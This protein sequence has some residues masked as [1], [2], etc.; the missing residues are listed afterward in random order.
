MGCHAFLQGV[1]L[2]RGS[3]LRLLCLVQRQERI[4]YQLSC[5]WDLSLLNSTRQL[6]VTM[7]YMTCSLIQSVSSVQSLS[8]VRLF[9]TP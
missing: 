1:F 2:T 6:L 7:S 9:V 3:N 4:L 5:A 8:H